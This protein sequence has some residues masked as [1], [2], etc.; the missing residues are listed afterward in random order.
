MA[1]R[2]EKENSKLNINEQRFLI[3]S[4]TDLDTIEKDYVCGQGDRAELPDGSYY[5]RH[6]DEYQGEK[7]ELM[8]SSG[9]GG[10]GSDLPAVTSADNGKVLTVVNGTWDKA[11]PSLLIG[12]LSWS[13]ADNQYIIDIP[14]E[15]ASQA[16]ENGNPILIS[17]KDGSAFVYSLNG[18]KGGAKVGA[19]TLAFDYWHR[20]N[21]E[22]FTVTSYTWNASQVQQYYN[23]TIANEGIALIDTAKQDSFNKTSQK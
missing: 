18:I 21:D 13:N 5:I 8:R 6:S 14:Y 23:Y 3:D 20:E 16:L 9:G 11:A 17:S 22:Y 12:H 7:W 10:G 1:I 4:K 2:L 19:E 15:D